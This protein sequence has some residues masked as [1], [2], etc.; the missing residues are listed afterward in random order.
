M[1][2]LFTAKKK[3]SHF[4]LLFHVTVRLS[5]RVNSIEVVVV[6]EVTVGMYSSTG[7][8][9]LGRKKMEGDHKN[10]RCP[11]LVLSWSA[12]YSLG[13][14]GFWNIEERPRREEGGSD[15]GVNISYM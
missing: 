8:R 2:F 3:M 14:F 10:T 9:V 5:Q 12:L 15:G 11:A 6:V 1:V 7:R 4:C 13:V